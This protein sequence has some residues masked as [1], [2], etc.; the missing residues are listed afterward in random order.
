MVDLVMG[1]KKTAIDKAS[2]QFFSKEEAK[3]FFTGSVSLGTQSV[4]WT[5]SKALQIELECPVQEKWDTA[6]DEKGKASECKVNESNICIKLNGEEVTIPK[7]KLFQV[8]IP[9]VVIEYDTVKATMK[10]CSFFA[11]I[12]IPKDKNYIE[13]GLLAFWIKDPSI[14]DKMVISAFIGDVFKALG[15]LVNKLELPKMEFTIE[16]VDVQLKNPAIT[17][18]EKTVLFGVSRKENEVPELSEIVVQNEDVFLLCHS[19]TVLD[20]AHQ[21]LKAK[22]MP[23]TYN[24][25]IKKAGVACTGKAVLEDVTRVVFADNLQKLQG[26]VNYSVDMKVTCYGMGCSITKAANSL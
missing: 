10:D 2:N 18:R 9:E 23:Y 6:F 12:D 26:N 21:A 25:D 13:I 11:Q 22:L 14:F 24:I 3:K 20:I 19:S 8:I 5:I 4:T 16:G 15:K 1:V 17:V 7:S